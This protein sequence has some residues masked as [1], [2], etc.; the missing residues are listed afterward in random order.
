MLPFIALATLAQK[1]GH[2][3]SYHELKKNCEEIKKKRH[4]YAKAKVQKSAILL[5]NS[6]I[7]SP[8]STSK[9]PREYDLLH[10]HNYDCAGKRSRRD[11]KLSKF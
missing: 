4:R 9:T 3:K 1:I 5:E 7:V 10:P 6:F 8:E 2:I 11:Q